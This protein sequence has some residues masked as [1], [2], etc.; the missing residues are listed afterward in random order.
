[1]MVLGRESPKVFFFA[2]SKKSYERHPLIQFSPS[3]GWC[4]DDEEEKTARV[5]VAAPRTRKDGS[6]R[7]ILV[8]VHARD[9]YKV[10]RRIHQHAKEK[11]ARGKSPILRSVGTGDERTTTTESRVAIHI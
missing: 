8:R 6:S 11:G 10:G 4:R 5:V 3:C 1:M 2:A 9:E 7:P